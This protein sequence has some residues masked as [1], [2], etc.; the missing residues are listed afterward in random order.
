[1]NRVAV[2]LT[3]VAA[4]AGAPMI[5]RTGSASRPRPTDDVLHSITPPMPTADR[6]VLLWCLLRLTPSTHLSDD[7]NAHRI[8]LVLRD[9]IQLM[10]LMP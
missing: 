7:A 10:C 1:V 6:D 9:W 8:A 5:G 4:S 3:D 2:W